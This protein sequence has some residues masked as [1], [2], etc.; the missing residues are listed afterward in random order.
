VLV[1]FSLYKRKNHITKLAL[2]FI[3]FENAKD[4]I[5]WA[6]PITEILTAVVSLI[7]LKFTKEIKEAFL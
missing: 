3:N 6:F 1:L 7:L 4:V 2:I 5:W